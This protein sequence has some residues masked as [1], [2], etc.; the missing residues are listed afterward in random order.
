MS[1]YPCKPAPVYWITGLSGAGKT[2]LAR[3]LQAHL[4]AQ[5]LP[6]TLVDGDVLRAI[7][8]GESG[9][10]IASRR[11][12]AMQIARCCDWLSQQGIPVVCATI[13]LFHDCQRWNREHIPE[14]KEILLRVS[15]E[16]LVARDQ[17]GLYSAARRGEGGEVVG[18]DLEP[19]WPEQ[20]DVILDGAENF[21][22]AQLLQKLL[23]Q[24]AL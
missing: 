16:T 7:I 12:V 18:L 13:S 11:I 8:G 2:T 22:P 15:L 19:E 23:D 3:L 4:R 24:L 5:G 10:D 9:Y 20:P 21:S 14:Y 1:E 17:K 6:A